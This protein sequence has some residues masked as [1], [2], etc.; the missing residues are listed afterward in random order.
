MC[1]THIIWKKPNYEMWL[2]NVILEF[3]LVFKTKHAIP[4]FGSQNMHWLL[5]F[6]TFEM[7][8]FHMQVLHFG[9]RFQ[10]LQLW[11]ITTKIFNIASN[12]WENCN[13]RTIN[14][15][16]C[17]FQTCNIYIGSQNM[18]WLLQF[19]AFEITCFHMWGM[20]GDTHIKSLKKS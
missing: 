11:V 15:Y 19:L 20:L 13:I 1:N 12:R 10:L 18:Q 7:A 5:Q 14:A 4:T 6:F 8:I 2:K 16:V 17:K 3:G 9:W